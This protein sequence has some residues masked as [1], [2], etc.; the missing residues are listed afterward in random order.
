MLMLCLGL[1]Q[2]LSPLS[3]WSSNPPGDHD[4]EKLIKA[5]GKDVLFHE[6]T[7]LGIVLVNEVEVATLTRIHVSRD[8][9]IGVFG[10]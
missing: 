1:A 7:K 10:D 2:S 6:L 8:A 3:D 4:D 5:G 9:H